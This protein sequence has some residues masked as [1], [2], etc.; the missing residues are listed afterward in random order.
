MFRG[1]MHVSLRL[2]HSCNLTLSHWH[3]DIEPH[4]AL[5]RQFY[6]RSNQIWCT[7]TTFGYSISMY[8]LQ[9]EI[10]YKT[11]FYMLFHHAQCD[12]V[13]YSYI[14]PQSLLQNV[15]WWTYSCSRLTQF[16]CLPP[17]WHLPLSAWLPL[18]QTHMCK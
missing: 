12:G 10:Y 16:T 9:H 8:W 13:R 4:C 17:S 5:M 18:Q 2:S 7:E 14:L 6:L 11:T 15:C 1:T 3:A